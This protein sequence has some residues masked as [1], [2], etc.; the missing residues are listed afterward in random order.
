MSRIKLSDAEKDALVAANFQTPRSV[1]GFHEVKR[2]TQP[3]VWVIRVLEHDAA[4]IQVLWEEQE[5]L[6]M[7]KIHDGGLFELVMAPLKELTPYKLKITYV[8]GVEVLRNDPYYFTPQLTEYDCYLFNQGNHHQIYRKLGSHPTNIEGVDGVLFA[9]WAPNAQRVSVVGDFNLWDG[10][11]N[12]M[13]LVGHSGIWEVFIPHVKQG[14]FYKY[15]IKDRHGSIRLK[16]D[17]YCVAMEQRPSTASMVYDLEGHQWNDR[18][19]LDHRKNSN[20]YKEPVSIYEVHLGSWRRVPHEENR[21]LTYREAADQLIPYVK[22]MGYTHIELLPVAEHPLDA[23]WGYQVIGFF[24]VTSRFGTPH[25]FMYF[26]DRCHQEGIGVLVDWV[27]GHFP[28]DETGLVYFDGTHLYEHEDTRKGEHLEWGTLVFNYGRHEVSN[29]LISNALFWF[30]V[31]HIDGIRVDAVASMLYLDYGRKEGEWL[32]NKYGGKENVDAIDFMRRLNE[33]LFSYHQGILTVAEESTSWTGVT[34]PTY[35]GG[36]GFNFKWNMG[37]MNDTLRYMSK[38]PVYRKYDHHLITFS[39]MYA[40]SE[41]FIL[42]ISHDEVVHGKSSLL[43]KMPGDAWQQRAN[44]RLYLF[45]QMAHPGKQLLFMGSEFGQWLEWSEARSLDWHLLEFH[46]HRQLQDFC[47]E[48]NWFYRRYPTLYTNDFS[49]K[50]FEWIDLHDNDNSVL[51]FLRRGDENTQDPPI[52]FVINA[53][54]VPRNQYMIGVPDSGLYHKI[55]DTDS[56]RFGGSGYNRQDT[57]HSGSLEW[58][59]RPYSLCLDLPPLAGVAFSLKQ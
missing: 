35:T 58:Q 27:P 22:D 48:N 28:K 30:D 10:R 11:K 33:V 59:G 57:I 49:W 41:N 42:P 23:S 1:L 13:H 38:T 24:A 37:W 14:A 50:G 19:W 8:N 31:Y 53:T 17:P 34:H 4:S 20:I 9:V 51:S 18:G 5:P 46:E 40:F 47:R 36:L 7:E 55:F 2:T 12:P 25:D 39:L 44:F 26:V 32:P 54:P 6:S 43:S 52:I 45:F 15:E 21:F 16:T 29:F 56:P 3:P